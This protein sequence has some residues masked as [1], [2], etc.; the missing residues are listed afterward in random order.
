MKPY[1]EILE[2]TF[3]QM[4]VIVLN[5]V[6]CLEELLTEF[7]KAK[8]SGATILDSRGMAMELA[9]HNDLRFIGSLRFLLEPQR[10]ENKTIFMVIE[11]EKVAT[12]SK[13]VNK[14]TGGL[15]KPNT[16]II[17]TVPVKYMEGIVHHE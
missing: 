17:F 5:K 12:V 3:M 15:D 11:E 16:G 1:Y 9:E 10:K 7:G 8:I 13:I 6:E 14:V 2:G 4:L